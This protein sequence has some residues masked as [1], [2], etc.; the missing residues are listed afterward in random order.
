MKK[1]YDVIANGQVAS[2]E[3]TKQLA[4]STARSILH[5]Q[6]DVRVVVH[7]S[8]SMQGGGF[9]TQRIWPTVGNEYGL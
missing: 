7:R 2:S 5:K 3:H 9:S 8:I 4:L 6:P 1:R